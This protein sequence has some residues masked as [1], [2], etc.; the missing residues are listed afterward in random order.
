MA[1]HPGSSQLSAF[2]DLANLAIV[3][4]QHG[5]TRRRTVV[6]G[7]LNAVFAYVAAYHIQLGLAMIM[8]RMWSGGRTRNGD[9]LDTTTTQRRLDVACSLACVPRGS[10]KVDEAIDR[11]DESCLDR[12]RKHVS[13]VSTLCTMSGYASDSNGSSVACQ[14]GSGLTTA[15]R[16][17]EDGLRC[18]D[19]TQT[20]ANSRDAPFLSIL[21]ALKAAG[22][23]I[24]RNVF[25]CLSIILFLVGAIVS[26][27]SQNDLFLDTGFLLTVWLFFTST[28][29]S[30][31]RHLTRHHQGKQKA[32]RRPLITALATALNPVLWTSICLLCY[33]LAKSR[34]LGLPTA[35]VVGLFKT[36][37]AI[38][39]L[40]AHHIDTTYLTLPNSRHNSTTSD[41]SSSAPITPMPIGAGDIATSILNAGIVTWGL[42]LFEYRTQIISRG[43]L[44]ALLTSA[45]AAAVNVIVWPLLAHQIGVRPAATDLS[46]AAR[47]VTIALGGPA[48]ASLGG[49]AGINAVGVV[50]NG[51]FFQLAAGFFAGAEGGFEGVVRRW[52]AAVR[53][54]MRAWFRIESVTDNEVH[55][56][57]CDSGSCQHAIPRDTVHDA[58]GCASPYTRR[59]SFNA[60]L[61]AERPAGCSRC[62]TQRTADED[63]SNPRDSI[64]D[65]QHHQDQGERIQVS[66]A[67]EAKSVVA[68]V[69]IGIN[70]AAMG[71][72]HLYEQDSLAAPYSA[73][74]MTSLGVFTVLFTM[75]GPLV[76][77]L[78]GMLGA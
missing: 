40:I 77:W 33:G 25:L 18:M 28:Q 12:F 24:R 59:C 39:D 68:G 73:L 78:R 50:I 41:A 13:D 27:L 57:T 54:Q 15:V 49:D 21:Q 19:Q 9:V 10:P 42:K 48:L 11:G 32:S 1:H 52:K 74:S 64:T 51:I 46:F 76:E 36:N 3:L 63:A 55:S 20:D 26:R 45:L 31:K 38:S 44:A 7:I 69:T 60:T 4:L 66:G 72:A 67:D 23:C 34:I 2:F 61:T 30:M 70:A 22:L 75:H 8:E 43:G 58:C 71:T 6:T 5:L 29:A 16:Q 47:G 56:H 14:E 53:L 17:A 62:R 35:T 37:N 65:E